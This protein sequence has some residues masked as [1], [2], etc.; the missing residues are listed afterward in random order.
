MNID[1]NPY[2]F[3]SFSVF[4]V[5]CGTGVGF[6]SS[7]AKK[8]KNALLHF[9]FSAVYRYIYMRERDSNET[10]KQRVNTI[11]EDIKLNLD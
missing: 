11:R 8:V 9:F 2:R 5:T 1:N 6:P 3:F 7:T 4:G 10:N